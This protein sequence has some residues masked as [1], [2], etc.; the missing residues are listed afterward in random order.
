MNK[1]EFRKSEKAYFI[2]TIILALISIGF[3]LLR[4]DPVYTIVLTAVALIAWFLFLLKNSL[5]YGI[6][7][8]PSQKMIITALFFL[9]IILSIIYLEIKISK[10][11]EFIEVNPN[12]KN[13]KF[14]NFWKKFWFVV[15][16]DNSFK[17]WIISLI[18]LLIVIRGIFFPIL[19][20]TTGTSMP[21]VIVESCSMYHEGGVFSNF[22][23]WWNR[24]GHE[25]KYFENKISENQFETFPFMN[26]FNKGDILFV[27]GVKPQNVKIGDVI[28]F[29]AGTT[30][31]IIHRVMSIKNENGTYIFS[32]EGDNNNGQLSVE[33]RINQNQLVGEPRAN[34]LPYIGWVKLI[35]FENSKPPSERGFCHEN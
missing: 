9:G 33:Q 14:S 30:A 25:M 29:N 27:T 20:L 32:T 13:S 16:K 28:I 31:P 26:G 22:S 17:G 6:I 35:F 3:W 23:A 8:K 24:G 18:F 11:K 10:T 5:R 4:L 19:S 21:L 34:I 2:V 12:R 15:W 1:K 7:K